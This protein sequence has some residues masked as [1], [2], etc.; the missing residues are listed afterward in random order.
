MKEISQKQLKLGLAALRL[1]LPES[2]QAKM[3]SLLELLEQWNRVH[4]LT[5]VRR[6]E[7]MIDRHLLDSLV[8]LPY[9][10]AAK[11]VCD[12]GTG[13]GFPGLPLAIALPEVEFV[14]LDS[15][16]KK[17]QFV[18]QAILTLGL[19][20]VTAVHTRVEQ[21]DAGPGFDWV[22]SRA[23]T[24]LGDFVELAGHLATQNGSL[25][26][27]KANLEPSEQ[28]EVPSS[29]RIAQIQPVKVPG[30]AKKRVLVF[31]DSVNHGA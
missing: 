22:L 11:R 23:M 29:H 4:N 31:M 13:A 5:A 15:S 1:S 21:Y 18:Q 9:L 12:V 27:W 17:I 14:L 25:L 30:E 6:F 3:L 19:P 10:H 28:S 26:A 24:S 2:S 8:A 20:H 7:D 16:L